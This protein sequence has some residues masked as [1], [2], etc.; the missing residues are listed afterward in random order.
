VFGL[1]ASK[2]GWN[3]KVSEKASEYLQ[4]NQHREP[5][6]SARMTSLVAGDFCMQTLESSTRRGGGWCARARRLKHQ[7]W[8]FLVLLDDAEDGT[9]GTAQAKQ[10]LYHW[11]AP[12]ACFDFRCN[13]LVHLYTCTFCRG[14][15]ILLR[16]SNKNFS[17]TQILKSNTFVNH[18]GNS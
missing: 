8:L 2:D 4:W 16:I 12:P 10:V 13:L 17:L 3:L 5:C 15:E 7:A 14:G 18:S 11:A 6:R 1:V 9:W